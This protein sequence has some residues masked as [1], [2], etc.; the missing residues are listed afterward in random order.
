VREK[1][2]AGRQKLNLDIL[3]GFT[4]GVGVDE[5]GLK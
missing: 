3:N 1:R 5:K 4:G 2:A